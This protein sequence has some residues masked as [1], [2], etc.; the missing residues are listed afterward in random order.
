MLPKI[1]PVPHTL[2]RHAPS[3]ALLP[4][5]GLVAVGCHALVIGTSS[6]P[7]WQAHHGLAFGFLLR[8][9][10]RFAPLVAGLFIG[11]FLLLRPPGVAEPLVV[12]VALLVT[13]C[14]AL[15]SGLYVRTRA[16]RGE[17]VALRDVSWFLAAA[18]AAAVPAAL[19]L[20]YLMAPAGLPA[21]S[22]GFDG[23]AHVWLAELMGM[24]IV[25]PLVMV[26]TARDYAYVTAEFWWSLE[27]LWQAVALLVVLWLILGAAPLNVTQYFYLAYVPLIWVST[28]YGIAG[29]TVVVALCQVLL[30]LGLFLQDP[31]GDTRLTIQWRMLA[32]TISGLYLGQAVSERRGMRNAL[33]ERE[34]ELR[35]VLL[36]APD[37][38]FTVDPTGRILSANHAAAQMFGVTAADLAE[39]RFW[40]LFPQPPS[41]SAQGASHAEAQGRRADG[42][43]F[44]VEL[45]LRRAKTSNREFDVAIARDVSA[46]KNLERNLALQRSSIQRSLRQAAAGELASTITHELTQPLSALGNYAHACEILAGQLAV[47]APRLRA[48]LRKLRTEAERAVQVLQRLRDFFRGGRLT[49]ERTA[50]APLIARVADAARERA[51]AHG[52]RVEADLAESAATADIDQVQIETVLHNLLANA[53]ESVAESAS[54]ARL[55]RVAAQPDGAQLEIVVEDSGPGVAPHVEMRLFEPFLTTKESGLGLGLAICRTFIEAHGGSLGLDRSPLGGA[56]FR[57]LLPMEGAA[58]EPESANGGQPRG[59]GPDV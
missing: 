35:T 17:P 44:D 20:T 56:R 48:T 19:A 34:A 23:L 40:S 2:R 9:G 46:R 22:A 12:G 24:L 39:K 42:A 13:A 4:V 8:Y 21:F 1:P 54:H 27:L 59:Q 5:Y 53:I 16:F 45:S 30:L 32:L 47:D 18:G 11:E 43:L 7:V 33:L 38:I 51:V 31:A 37:A 10:V 14:F 25:A 28:R 49:R 52:I 6:A 15:A 36:S 29:A 41:M 50:I 3:L 57:L 58:Q 55:V 26:H